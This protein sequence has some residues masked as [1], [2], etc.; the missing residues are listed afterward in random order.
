MYMHSARV[1]PG[2]YED[3]AGSG[4]RLARMPGGGDREADMEVM[5]A[6]AL[7]E[8][9]CRESR[10]AYRAVLARFPNHYAANC[11]LGADL[12]LSGRPRSSLK[13]FARAIKVWPESHMAYAGMGRSLLD[14]GKYKTA[15]NVL[16]M[17]LEIQPDDP[18][19]LESRRMAAKKMSK[20]RRRVRD[21][22][23]TPPAGG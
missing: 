7:C 19:A 2:R 20:R 10:R 5:R 1:P 17:A 11:N 23:G 3:Q 4:D 18:F 14:M 6:A 22:V 12:R 8:K 16:D 21:A 15:I 13:Y 9:G